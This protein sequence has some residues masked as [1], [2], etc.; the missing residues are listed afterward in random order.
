MSL[1]KRR[2]I[3]KKGGAAVK[4]ENRSF[5]KSPALAASAGK[6]GGETTRDGGRVRVKAS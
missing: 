5:S 4:P 6:K 2:A 1:E 3:A